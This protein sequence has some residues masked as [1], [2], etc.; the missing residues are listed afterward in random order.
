MIRSVLK[1]GVVAGA[2]LSLGACALL[3]TPD[4]VQMYRFGAQMDAPAP[5]GDTPAPLLVSIRRIEFPDASK[6]ARIL[7]VTGT[8]TAYIG[9]ARWVSPAETLFDDSL[10][11]A[12]AARPDQ[13]R[14]LD[15]REPG[16]TP[17]VLRVTVS[18]FEARYLDGKD[19]APTVVITARAQLRNTPERERG[20]GP[21]R[22]E[23]GRTVERV[24]SV[25]QPAGENRVSAIVQAFDVATRDINTR[26]VDWSISSAP[27]PLA[28]AR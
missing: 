1:G 11:A 20:A 21:I 17:L 25:T 9:G 22:P 16:T 2:A 3:S 10:N 19:A 18:S 7:G 28:A 8:E 27:T 15:R 6:D 13:V 12:F 14:V 4:P 26:I 24:F 23:D 5:A